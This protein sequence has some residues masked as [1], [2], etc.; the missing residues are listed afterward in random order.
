MASAKILKP[1]ALRKGDR[2]G[3]IAPASSFSR[4]GFRAG[5]ERLRQ[6]GYEPVYSEQ[7]FDRDLYFAGTA[8]RRTREL[9]ELWQRE[10][11][12]ALVCVRG[13]YGSNYLLENLDF[14]MFARQPKILIGCSDI[15]TLLTAIHDRTGLVTFHG[16]MVAKDIGDGTID[17]SSWNNS[18]GG[19]AEWNVPTAGV[20]V[21]RPG[22]ARGKVY[23]GCL[24]LLAASLGTPFE[25]ETEGTLLFI[26]DIGERPY[27]ID[28]M[29]MQLRLAGKLENVRGFLFGE[30]LG[31]DRP[32]DETYTLQQV[33]TRVLE[34]YNVPVIFGL[35]SGHV[36]GSN[37]TL[38]IGLQAELAA[39][40][41]EA[42]LRILESATITAAR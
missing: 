26:E 34:P 33:I 12:R 5:S 14:E 37:I 17:L 13:G 18:L 7:I 9:K 19:S 35:K 4:E 42:S 6:M 2:I 29:L 11:I 10:D 41:S 38:P 30:M 8:E 16:P 28:R 1:P 3:L 25:I 36:T 20:E 40:G 21:L 27:R 23:G 24:S 31:C 22:R 32:L 15:T 39:E